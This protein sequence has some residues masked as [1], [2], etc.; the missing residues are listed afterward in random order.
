M[1]PIFLTAIIFVITF[2]GGSVLYKDNVNENPYFP[3]EVREIAFGMFWLRMI[4][5]ICCAC[6]LFCICCIFVCA[7]AAGEPI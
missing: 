6:G 3:K 1:L 5:V 4:A 2:W 7:L